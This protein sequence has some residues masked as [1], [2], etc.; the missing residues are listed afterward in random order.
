MTVPAFYRLSIAPDLRQ[1]EP[2]IAY[3]CEFLDRAHAVQRVERADRVLHYGDRPPPGA[4]AVPAALFPAGASLDEDGIHPV[5]D[6]LS[7]IEAGQGRNRLLPPPGAAVA[8]GAIAYDALGLIFHQISRIEERDSVYTD[9]YGRF[10]IGGALATRQDSHLAPLADRAARDLAALIRGEKRPAN[11]TQYCVL[12]THDVDRLRGYHRPHL[13]LR[14]AAG[15]LVRRRDPQAAWKR[16]VVGYLSRLPWSSFNEIMDLSE[17]YGQQSRFYFMGPTWLSNDSPYVHTMPRLLRRLGDAVRHRGHIVGFHP[18]YATATDPAEWTRQREGL[19]AALDCPVL[20]GRQHTLR[21][22]STITPDI[23]EDADMTMDCTLSYPETSSFRAGTCRPF[24]G[25]SLRRRRP[26]RLV[27]HSTAV[28]DFGLFGGKYRD[29]TIDEA[30]AETARAQ[31]VCRE[32]G[33]TLALLYHAGQPLAPQRPFYK[34]LL[35]QAFA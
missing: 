29:L 9:R 24:R 7:G 22:D 26:R 32:Y 25:Y 33:G 1:F 21:Y 31:A 5:H 4:L 13:P 14:Y 20:E 12:L 30:L 23:W 11:R 28:M 18:G 3:A 27:Q 34:A 10:S 19:E 6:A 2:E 16:I 17:H 15:D 35:R 8:G